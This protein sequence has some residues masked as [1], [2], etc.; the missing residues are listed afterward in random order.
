MDEL[1]IEELPVVVPVPVFVEVPVPVRVPVPVAELEEATGVEVIVTPAA[2]VVV[3]TDT[4]VFVIVAS[5]ISVYWVTSAP[6]AFVSVTSDVSVAPKANL[7]RRSTVKGILANI[8]AFKI[9]LDPRVRS[10][11]QLSS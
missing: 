4:A 1:L 6:L 5:S 10:F 3:T 9:V 8:V 2:F 11:V 7:Q